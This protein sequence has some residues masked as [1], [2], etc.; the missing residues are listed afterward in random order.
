MENTDNVGLFLFSCGG[1]TL[2][3]EPYMVPRIEPR[4]PACKIKHPL[5]HVTY[6]DWGLGDHIQKWDRSGGPLAATE[7]GFVE[8]RRGL[9]LGLPGHWGTYGGGRS[10][11]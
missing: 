6:T 5:S 3:R 4:L 9:E 7:E 1:L 2:L 8:S 11:Q 10:C